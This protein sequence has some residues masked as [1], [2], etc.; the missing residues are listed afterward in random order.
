M[1]EVHS[2][3]KQ[4]L[5]ENIF[6]FTSWFEDGKKRDQILGSIVKSN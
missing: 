4:T 1:D 5:Q 6:T 2:W 3:I